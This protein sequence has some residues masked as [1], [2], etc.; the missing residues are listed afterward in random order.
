MRLYR[1]ADTAQFQRREFL[2][3]AAAGVG[4]MAT[5]GFKMLSAA[6][7][8]DSAIKPTAEAVIFLYMGGGQA[9]AETW[10]LQM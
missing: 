6:E 5:G 3:L 7:S 9:A 2:R 10:D 8:S 1:Y 4:V